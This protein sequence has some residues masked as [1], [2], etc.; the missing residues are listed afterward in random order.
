MAT[1]TGEA[2]AV[3]AM[4]L[5][6]VVTIHPIDPFVAQHILREVNPA[7]ALVFRDIPQEI[8]QLKRDAQVSRTVQSALPR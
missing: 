3:P 4:P 7:P 2:K 1:V 5:A 8:G 6:G